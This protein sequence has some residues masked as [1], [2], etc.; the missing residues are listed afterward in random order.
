M[1]LLLCWTNLRSPLRDA[2]I[3]K[4]LQKKK[5]ASYHLRVLCPSKRP[6]NPDDVSNEEVRKHNGEPWM[7][8]LTLEEEPE[9]NL[10]KPLYSAAKGPKLN[11]SY[12][13]THKGCLTNVKLLP[14]SS[15]CLLPQ[16]CVTRRETSSLRIKLH[17][18]TPQHTG[19]LIA[20]H[21]FRVFSGRGCENVFFKK[22]LFV[23]QENQGDD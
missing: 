3:K 10:A 22:K 18:P 20:H 14:P 21:R 12:L 8:V 16:S 6:A 11:L 2:A 7:C 5:C 23:P 19:S 4:K 13:R 9:K 15:S 1:Q 17:L